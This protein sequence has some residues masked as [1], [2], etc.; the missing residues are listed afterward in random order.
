L[1]QGKR[2]LEESVS[3]EEFSRL[4]KPVLKTKGLVYS[5]EYYLKRYQLNGR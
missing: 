2:N 1:I 4:L 3:V 5:L